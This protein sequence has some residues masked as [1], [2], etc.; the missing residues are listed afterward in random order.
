M[1]HDPADSTFELVKY[2]LTWRCLSRVRRDR[3]NPNQP[4]DSLWN[5]AKIGVSTI[6]VSLGDSTATP[7][8][9]NRHLKPSTVDEL[10]KF[11]RSI[12]YT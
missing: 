5:A 1:R 2:Y 10:A 11:G 3:P 12:E 4:P 6:S 9:E 7:A 8:R